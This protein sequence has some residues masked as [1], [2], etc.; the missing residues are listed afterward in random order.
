VIEKAKRKPPI[1]A[2]D[3]GP[4]PGDFPI[5]SPESRAAARALISARVPKLTRYDRDC[6]EIVTMTRLLHAG[7]WPSYSE[8][9]KLQVWQHGWELVRSSVGFPKFLETMRE[10]GAGKLGK[11]LF[12]SSEFAGAHGREASA[13]D[14]LRWTVLKPCI[15]V[16]QVNE[17]RTIWERR[18]PEYPFPFKHQTGFL[19]V[20]AA[21]YVLREH[22]TRTVNGFEPVWHDVPQFRWSWVEDEALGSDSSW[23]DVQRCWAAG[24]DIADL[25]PKIQAVLFCE[26]GTVKP[27]ETAGQTGTTTVDVG[28]NM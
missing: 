17:W 18:V 24:T 1:T 7:A 22:G 14:V 5:G 11:C 4:R 20:R 19:F 3:S 21:D 9:E 27:L 28:Q 25:T 8:M 6:M 15:K 13:G 26:D 10:V 2:T 12:A 23:Y 16:E